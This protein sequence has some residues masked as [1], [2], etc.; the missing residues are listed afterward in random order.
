[1]YN[2]ASKWKIFT[3]LMLFFLLGLLRVAAE[4][5]GQVQFSFDLGEDFTMLS[6]LFPGVFTALAAEGSGLQGA[7]RVLP[8]RAL[9]LPQSVVFL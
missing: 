8:V 1:M 6:G 4:G 5:F 9:R 7:Q 2:I 3:F